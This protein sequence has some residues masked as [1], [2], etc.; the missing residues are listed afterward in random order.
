MGIVLVTGALI[1]WW[2]SM[3]AAT[4]NEAPF[5]Q[6][7]IASE[8]KPRIGDDRDLEV[9]LLK[10]GQVMERVERIDCRFRRYRYDGTFLREGRAE[11]RFSVSRDGTVDY[12]CEPV[13]IPA[14]T[15]SRRKNGNTPFSLSSDR[16]ETL[17]ITRKDLTPML[18]LR[19][20]LPL[21]DFLMNVSRRKMSA[22]FDITVVNQTPEQIRILFVPRWRP[23]TLE[24]SKVELILNRE[25]F[26][27]Y[28]LRIVDPSGNS[29]TVH[30]LSDVKYELKEAK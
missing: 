2:D 26:V 13:D 17:H 5:D 19:T 7:A 8:P 27:P 30:V 28:A 3:P 9:I 24:Y 20:Q 12:V 11:G 29:E 1:W 21:E 25:G 10:W 4:S 23:L 15:V 6:A 14:G 18:A 22:R 16:A